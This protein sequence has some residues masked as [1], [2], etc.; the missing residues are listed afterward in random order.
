MSTAI[1][2][3]FNGSLLAVFDLATPLDF[4]RALAPAKTGLSEARAVEP[5]VRAGWLR[6]IADR[7]REREIEFAHREASFE[8]LPS[9]VVLEKSIRS[10]ERLFRRLAE[11]VAGAA[12]DGRVP[13]GLITVMVQGGFATRSIAERLA[14]ALAA[15]NA[16]FIGVSPSS[17]SALSIWS[18]VAASVPPGLVNVLFASEETTALMVSHP[19]IRAVTFA[20][21][22]E[23]AGRIA[24]AAT[25]SWKK[26]QI[27]SGAKN[28][29]LIHPDADFSRL[30]DML[31]GVLIGAGRLPW[32][33]TRI[34]TT[35][36][37][38]EEVCDRLRAHWETLVPL[39][40][41]EGGSSWTPTPGARLEPLR[42]ML[43]ADHA[44]I[45][46]GGGAL[47][48][49]HVKPLVV[50][51]LTNCSTLQ[52]EDLGQPLIIVNSVK[53]VHEMAKWTNTGEFAFAA[54]LWGPAD[55]ARVLAAKLEAGRVWINGWLEGD[56][57]FAGWKKSFFGDPDFRWNGGFYSDV[58]TLTGVSS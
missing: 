25:A 36:A 22:L 2:S 57:A 39:E 23:D 12:D 51:D 48:E 42:P 24:A 21:R 8:G 35:D 3:P 41:P 32:S 6:A 52:L 17:A 4:V 7:L 43:A 44:K 40:T 13:T 31:A 45:V 38:L 16:V 5:A 55:K 28:G 30:P 14:P 1:H 18:E 34:F 19:S 11:D 15:G 33:L 46:A 9:S 53:Y 29:L 50:R 54:S 47:G 26:L 49:F 56:G 37:R 10:A 58:R 20:G 27:S